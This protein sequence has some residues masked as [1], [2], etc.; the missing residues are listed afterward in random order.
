MYKKIGILVILAIGWIESSEAQQ[1]SQYTQYMYNTQTINPAY[2]GN[3]GMLTFNALYRAQWVGLDGAPE[4]LNFSMNTPLGIRGIGFGLSFY[5]DKIKPSKESNIAA[6]V[7]YTVS[8]SSNLK[9]SLGVKGGINLLNVDYT[10]LS[11]YN[12]SDPH[13]NNNINNRRSPIIGAGFYL[14]HSDKWYLGVSSPNLLRTRHYDDLVASTVIESTHLYATGGYVFDFSDAIK[15]KPAVL[16]KY[17]SGS[18][19]A[20]EASANFMFNNKFTLGGAYRWDAGISALAAFSISDQLMIGYAYDFDT[21]RLGKY[22]SGSHE[23]FLRF[24]LITK[25]RRNVNP[26]FF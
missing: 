11:I 19:M 8:L 7:S 3:R 15:F 5:S 2:A 21:S 23:I 26:R 24:E 12:S 16:A 14:H 20:M 10:E 9:L 13:F 22:H 25:L 18:P 17:V 4:T 6:D 1:D